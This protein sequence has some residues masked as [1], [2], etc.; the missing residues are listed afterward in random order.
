MKSQATRLTE[1]QRAM[2]DYWT[3]KGHKFK[4]GEKP[5]ASTHTPPSLATRCPVAD[6]LVGLFV[7]VF[8]MFLLGM[9]VYYGAGLHG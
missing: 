6:A 8:C 1:E 9:W 7:I 5:P 3:C 4:A 2:F